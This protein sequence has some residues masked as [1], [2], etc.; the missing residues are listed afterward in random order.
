[1][2]NHRSFLNFGEFTIKGVVQLRQNGA[3]AA[4]LAKKIGFPFGH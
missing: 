4:R 2:T 3:A 1:L